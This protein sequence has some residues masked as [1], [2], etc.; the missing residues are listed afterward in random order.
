[1]FALQIASLTSR[2]W[3]NYPGRPIQ[4]HHDHA[5]CI[6]VLQYSSQRLGVRG[7][8]RRSSLMA[9]CGRGPSSSASVPRAPASTICCTVGS[10]RGRRP[11]QSAASRESKT[12]PCTVQCPCRPASARVPACFAGAAHPPLRRPRRRRARTLPP[13]ACAVWLPGWHYL[14][15]QTV[16]HL[17]VFFYFHARREVSRRLTCSVKTIMLN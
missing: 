13:G 7:A 10:G 8:A 1:M 16:L 4:L 3:V 11:W 2:S 9:N 6:T 5:Y 15:R 17:W 14:T 12:R